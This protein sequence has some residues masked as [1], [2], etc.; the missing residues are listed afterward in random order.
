MSKFSDNDLVDAG[1]L[2]NLNIR[3]A[4]FFGSALISVMPS[5]LPRH[6]NAAIKMAAFLRVAALKA[7]LAECK[8]VL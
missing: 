5:P 8:A 4:L 3:L 1:V 7:G 6:K 2:P